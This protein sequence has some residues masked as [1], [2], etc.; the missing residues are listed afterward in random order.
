MRIGFGYD[1]HPLVAGR[2]LI[3][4][5]VTIPFEQGLLGHSDADVVVHALCDALLGAL[6]LG[7]LGQH[8]PSTDERWR[9]ASSLVFL[10]HVTALLQE[11]QYVLGNAD[12]TVVAQRPR[13]SPYTAQMRQRLA[14]AASTALTQMSVK[15]TTTDHLGFAG[16][17]EGIAAYAVC[18]IQPVPVTHESNMG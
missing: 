18:V 13:L 1:V 3:L 12:I 15:A 17:G 4:G 9:G 10:Q 6:A 5:G 2:P 11:R 8:F 14:T 16:R 7:D